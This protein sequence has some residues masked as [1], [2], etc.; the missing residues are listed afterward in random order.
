[1]KKQVAMICAGFL[2]LSAAFLGAGVA[3]SPDRADAYISDTFNY[4]FNGITNL[5]NGF[6]VGIIGVGFEK[7]RAFDLFTSANVGVQV[8]RT[9]P[10]KSQLRSVKLIHRTTGYQLKALNLTNPLQA[11]RSDLTANCNGSEVIECSLHRGNTISGVTFSPNS[12]VIAEITFND[13]VY[14]V[15]AN[16]V[17]TAQ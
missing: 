13:G 5:P 15:Q 11:L 16:S 14:M 2:T 17:K 6:R 12:A 9:S 8:M 3:S 1:M 4:T 7:R 10:S